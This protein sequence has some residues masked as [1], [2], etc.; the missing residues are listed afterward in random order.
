MQGAGG[1]KKK[2]GSSPKQK[3]HQR[4]FARAAKKCKGQ[5]GAKFRACV[6]RE[7]KK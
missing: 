7:L 3:E 2:R 4:R 6:R 1:R 5:P